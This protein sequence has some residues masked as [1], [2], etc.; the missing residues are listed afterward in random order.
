MEPDPEPRTELGVALVAVA[1][2]VV[3]EGK[4]TV[5]KVESPE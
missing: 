1:V 2:K 4:R 5:P 3:V